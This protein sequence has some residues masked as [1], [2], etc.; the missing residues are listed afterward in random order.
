[1][2]EST[3]R[4]N[5][6]LFA[7]WSSKPGD[8]CDELVKLVSN[9]R[10]MNDSQKLKQ[11]SFFNHSRRICLL[12][13]P[14]EIEFEQ[15]T[16][17]LLCPNKNSK[18]YRVHFIVL[19]NREILEISFGLPKKQVGLLLWTHAATDKWQLFI[20]LSAV[21]EHWGTNGLIFIKI[22]LLGWSM[23]HHPTQ[24]QVHGTCLC[25]FFSTQS[26]W[27]KQGV[28]FYECNQHVIH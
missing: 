9:E 1:M 2:V 19:T 7:T 26:H 16:C 24:N 25:Y 14:Q 23:S 28:W 3:V 17:F 6:I 5:K 12:C 20:I 13:I 22:W 15:L 27:L 21:D 10:L 11:L 4:L 8:R 18:G